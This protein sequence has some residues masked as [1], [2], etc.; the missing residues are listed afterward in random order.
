MVY[1]R[2]AEIN[3]CMNGLLIHVAWKKFCLNKV[4]RILKI[5]HLSVYEL[6]YFHYQVVLITIGYFRLTEISENYIA[7]S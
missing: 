7:K 1:V 6:F 3:V 5:G 2:G 4:L